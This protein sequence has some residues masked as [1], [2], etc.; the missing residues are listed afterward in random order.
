MTSHI[1]Q[2]G[3]FKFVVVRP[4]ETFKKKPSS[5]ENNGQAQSTGTIGYTSIDGSIEPSIVQV[6]KLLCEEPN[7]IDKVTQSAKDFLDSDESIKIVRTRTTNNE[8]INQLIQVYDSVY[9]LVNEEIAGSQSPIH[10]LKKIV[11]EVMGSE[12]STVVESN[13][14][15]S[16]Y[17]KLWNTYYALIA[18]N[19]PSVEYTDLTLAIRGAN[20]VKQIAESEIG[21]ERSGQVRILLEA[22]PL[23]PRNILRPKVEVESEETSTEEENDN[24][25]TKEDPF[26]VN[27]QK[28]NDRLLK[29]YQASN[30]LEILLE[31]YRSELVA[32][33]QAQE[34]EKAEKKVARPTYIYNGLLQKF[35]GFLQSILRWIGF[36][37]TAQATSTIDTINREESNPDILPDNYIEQLTDESKQLFENSSLRI[38]GRSIYQVQEDIQAQ[39]QLVNKLLSRGHT[40]RSVGRIGNKWK[41]IEGSE[42]AF[43]R[44]SPEEQTLTKVL[45]IDP[46]AQPSKETDFEL[47]LEEE[48]IKSFFYK[49]KLE[50]ISNKLAQI[51]KNLKCISSIGIGDLMTV[52]QTLLRYVPGEVA[53]IENILKGEK[54]TRTHRRLNRTEESLFVRTESENETE[55]DLQSTERFEL[56]KES[57]KVIDKKM[58]LEAGV[59]ISAQYGPVKLETNAGVAME[60]SKSKSSQTASNFAQEVTESALSRITE[61]I[62]EERKD[63]TIEEIEEIN[64]HEID[65]AADSNGN[66]AGIYR[67]VDKIYSAQVFNYGKRLM[68]EFMIPEPAAFYKYSQLHNPS[69]DNLPDP[70][71]EIDELTPDDIKRSNY[72]EL[73]SKYR[74]TNIEPPPAKYIKKTVAIK[75]ETLAEEKKL[76]D[77]QNKIYVGE[78]SISLDGYTACHAKVALAFDERG[79]GVNLRDG[80]TTKYDNAVITVIVGTL[81]FVFKASHSED[82]ER[83]P[84]KIIGSLDDIL[85]GIFGFDNFIDLEG[86]T[87]ISALANKYIESAVINVEISFSCTKN[88]LREWQLKTYAAIVNQYNASQSDYEAAL[89]EREIQEGIKIEGRNPKYNKQIIDTELKRCCINSIIG[90]SI[91]STYKT[92]GLKKILIGIARFV[93]KGISNKGI[94]YDLLDAKQ[95]GEYIRFLEHA[96][97]WSQM[98]YVFYP[99][100]WGRVSKKNPDD[101]KS[102]DDKNLDYGWLSLMNQDDNDPLF[103]DFLRAG[104]SRVV[105]PVRPLFEDA[106]LHYLKTAEPWNGGDPPWMDGDD[107]LYVSIIQELKEQLDAPDDGILVGEPWEVTVPTSLVYLQPSPDLPDFTQE[108]T[109]ADNLNSLPEKIMN[110]KTPEINIPNIT[111][112]ELNRP[113]ETLAE[114]LTNDTDGQE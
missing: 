7:P 71:P 46:E 50:E 21:F 89:A 98:T 42:S 41:I 96:F 108:Q 88:K 95:D 38:K 16:S 101:K 9:T 13:D 19:Q 91:V 5:S 80:S 107:K 53:H 67:W 111:G 52:R 87:S 35:W 78:S 60:E 86:E 64:S 10:G 103:A 1:P 29:L 43:I 70:I 32:Q 85:T 22:V 49:K 102:D 114:A 61:R 109:E 63:K 57:Q 15:S 34:F 97:E 83:R 58:S 110:A 72:N 3:I 62:Y 99:Y 68:L 45:E 8:I 11:E 74:I 54:K 39:M 51:N 18:S 69:A 112:L 93:Y 65:N 28:L 56:Q 55:R 26:T 84:S 73:V 44:L 2:E 113:E 75:F 30:E 6:F 40:P 47:V 66:I 23:L 17:D 4:P 105:V 12:A 33:N 77:Y 27:Q 59:N 104:A 20:I 82:P 24:D 94:V 90:E 25:E 76:E 48:E 14:F 100:F 31:K 81:S 37:P 36:L 92:T 79:G 106:I